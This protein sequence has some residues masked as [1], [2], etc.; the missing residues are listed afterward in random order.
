LSSKIHDNNKLLIMKTILKT[1]ILSFL[2]T[3][4][5]NNAYSQKAEQPIL[6]TSC[7]QSP[8]PVRLKIFMTRLN[9]V[10]D[11]NLLATADDLIAKKKEGKPYKSLIIVTGASLKG[12]GAAGVSVEEELKRTAA[13]IAEAKKQGIKIIGAH[14]E[15]M[16]RRSAGAS[17][18]DNSDELSIDAVCPNSNMMII[19][20][21]GDSDGRFTT[22][23]KGKNIPIFMFELNNDITGILEQ[24]FINK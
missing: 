10:Y 23:S 16:A 20:K 18:G 22:I 9:L 3:F 11:Y 15:G 1:F 8:G 6:L 24:V 14:I 21:E 17:P 2:V 5:F 13:L 12:M 19:K 4:M 7:G